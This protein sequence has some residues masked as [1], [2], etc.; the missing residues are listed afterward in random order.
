MRIQRLSIFLFRL[1]DRVAHQSC[2]TYDGECSYKLS[3]IEETEKNSEVRWREQEDPARISDPAKPT[4]F[5]EQF[6]KDCPSTV[7]F[8]G[9]LLLVLFRQS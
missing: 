2:V 5:P 9:K 8:Q 4:S 1:E 6:L 7:S 3:Y